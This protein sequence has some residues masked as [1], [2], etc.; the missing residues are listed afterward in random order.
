MPSQ[1]EGREDVEELWY[2]RFCGL[3]PDH[4]RPCKEE[5]RFADVG[6]ESK[7]FSFVLT[8]GPVL[9]VLPSWSQ[10]KKGW[11]AWVFRKE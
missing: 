3:R 1:A 5:F 11:K 4:Q 7:K 6:E 8:V 10:K 9:I 2:L